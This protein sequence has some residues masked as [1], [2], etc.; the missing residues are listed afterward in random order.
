MLIRVFSY[1]VMCFL[2]PLDVFVIDFVNK[3]S[4]ETYVF[5]VPLF[6]L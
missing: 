5:L 1:Y 6:E 2:R 3:T 4:S